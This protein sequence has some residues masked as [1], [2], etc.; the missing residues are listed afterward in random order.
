MKLQYAAGPQYPGAGVYRTPPIPTPRIAVSDR[1]VRRDPPPR[2]RAVSPLQAGSIHRSRPRAC[3]VT[4][5]ATVNDRVA[6]RLAH[7]LLAE[8]IE[9][10]RGWER[11]LFLSR[12][13]C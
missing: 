4:R 7:A 12:G 1:T 9:R 6:L 2:M 8:R 13:R 10:E 5:D 11:A 3:E